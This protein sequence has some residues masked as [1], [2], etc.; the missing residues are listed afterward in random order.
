MKTEQTER[1]L[2]VALVQ[3][4]A[5]G[6][7]RLQALMEIERSRFSCQENC[8]SLAKREFHLDHD[9]GAASARKAARDCASEGRIFG[10]FPLADPLHW[11]FPP[12]HASQ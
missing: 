4:M 6:W 11:S 8:R 3:L 5:H 10:F 9:L 7:R 12:W 1:L 2:Q